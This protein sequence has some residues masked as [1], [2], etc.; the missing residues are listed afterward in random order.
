[1]RLLLATILAAAL[2]GAAHATEHEIRMLG[3]GPDDPMV[4]EPD[5]IHAAPGDTIRFV[6]VDGY[7]N[8]ETIRAMFPDGAEGFKGEIG[9]DVVMTL[10]E[11]GVYLVKC[12]S[13]YGVGMVALVVAGDMPDSKTLARAVAGPHPLR[14]RATFAAILG[15]IAEK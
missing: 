15:A 4:F 1:M 5:F 14:A 9:K 7:H 10:P 13:H 6:A 12:K 11:A 3:D 2:A 8:A